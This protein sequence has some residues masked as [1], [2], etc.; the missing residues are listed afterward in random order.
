MSRTKL[1]Q[2]LDQPQ[3]K[4]VRDKIITYIGDS[5]SRM[6]ELMDFFFH[7]EWRYNQKAAWPLGVIGEHNPELL[8]PHL[9]SMLDNLKDHP[10]DAVIRN[11]VR[12]LQFIDLS[13]DLEGPVYDICM[14]YL[15]DIKQAIAI[16][17][18][19]M[20][21]LANIA[22]KH[23]ELRSELIAVI[24]EYFEIESSG[25]KARA[26]KIIKRFQ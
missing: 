6:A 13:E 5:A 15:L 19:A 20:T 11:T 7:E 25:F 10:K 18:F 3:T 23:P 26:K 16:R 22:E 24:Q 1:S 9:Q 8:L 2:L 17:A 12:T 21:T 4:E 14:N